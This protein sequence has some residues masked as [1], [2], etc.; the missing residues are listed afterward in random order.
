MPFF[1]QPGPRW[2]W[3]PVLLRALFIP[4]FMFCNFNPEFRSL[5]VLIL[6][7][8]VYIFGGILL[9]FTSGYYSS[10]TMMF[11]PG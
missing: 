1:S 5:P 10:L 3:I 2:V 4:F 9:A 11:A 6:N 8:Y 7:D